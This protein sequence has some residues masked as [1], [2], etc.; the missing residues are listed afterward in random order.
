[1]VSK[2]QVFFFFF[3]YFIDVIKLRILVPFCF[4]TC[5]GVSLA[6]PKGVSKRKGIPAVFKCP[7]RDYIT[8]PSPLSPWPKGIFQGRGV[9]VHILRPPGAEILYAPLLYTP[10]TPR[11]VLPGVRG[12]GCTKF[13][14]AKCQIP[15][16]SAEKVHKSS[17]E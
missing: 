9:G 1:M 12:W 4:G 10:P 11:R 13:G 17:A 8:P 5:L 6:G 7:G 16:K 3:F 15:G 14:P 2:W